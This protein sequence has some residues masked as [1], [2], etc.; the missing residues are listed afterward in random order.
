[1]R[2][3]M[4][5]SHTMPAACIASNLPP[6]WQPRRAFPDAAAIDRVI[7]RASPCV[8]CKR[9]PASFRLH[10]HTLVAYSA[11]HP[12][13]APRYVRL[14]HGPGRQLCAEVKQAAPAA[15]GLDTTPP[16]PRFPMHPSAQTAVQNVENGPS[17]CTGLE[18]AA[19]MMCGM[20]A[21][22]RGA[23]YNPGAIA[24]VGAPAALPAARA[25]PLPV[26]L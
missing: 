6:A 22:V 17:V 16:H 13:P 2:A 12:L 5:G 1:M 26:W 24:S 20:S 14:H 3:C 23:L 19:A 4:P 21:D 15:T 8:Y 7:R 25:H 11:D 9:Q 18:G 10:M